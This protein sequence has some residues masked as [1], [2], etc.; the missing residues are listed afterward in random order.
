MNSLRFP[1][2]PPLL[3]SDHDATYEHLIASFS[4][5]ASSLL[6]R[7]S[8]GT[9]LPENHHIDANLNADPGLA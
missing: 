1:S 8:Y 3:V 2:C 6:L 4:I 7:Q 9:L 5:W